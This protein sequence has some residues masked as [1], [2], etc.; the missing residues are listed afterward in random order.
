MGSH[1]GL[2]LRGC[3]VQTCPFVILILMYYINLTYLITWT[4]DEWWPPP[5]W[6]SC[7]WCNTRLRNCVSECRM[8]VWIFE[9]SLLWI[10]RRF[11][12]LY[13][14]LCH[15]RWRLECRQSA[16]SYRFDILYP[17]LSRFSWDLLAVVMLNGTDHVTWVALQLHL[18]IARLCLF[19]CMWIVG[20]VG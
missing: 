14:W 9:T 10:Y 11:L 16:A 17:Y 5:T 19:G 6:L 15:R 13:D 20:S 4:I 18:C 1:C 8:L 12:C 7:V 3:F 2:S